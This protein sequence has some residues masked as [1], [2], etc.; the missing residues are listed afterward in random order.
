M[1]RLALIALVSLG[2]ACIVEA[3][4]GDG[5][6]PAVQVD[7]KP[8]T[9]KNGAVLGGK[10][11]LLG[12]TFAPG[13]LVPGEP[14]HVALYFRVLDP[15]DQ[16]YSVFVHV[17]DADGRVQRANFDHPPAGG[18]YP[19]SKWKKGETIRDEFQLL[20]PAGVPLRAINLYVGLWQPQ[21]DSRLQVTNADKVR[22]DG[23]NRVMLAQ[24]PVAQQ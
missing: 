24:V 21:S 9:V 5:E 8:A 7:R 16:D 13:T 15:I 20:V 1:R 22:T 4:G 23:Q 3:P 10:I 19:T 2:T 18:R 17:E 12:A 6:K 14:A 11:E